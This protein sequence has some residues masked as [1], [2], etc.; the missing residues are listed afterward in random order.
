M[1]ETQSCEMNIVDFN[2]RVID[3]HNAHYTNNPYGL[4]DHSKNASPNGNHIYHLYSN[5]EITF[6]KGAWAYMQRS[7]FNKDYQLSG[8]RKIPFKFVKE[9]ADG[10]TYAILTYEECK[11]FREEMQSYIK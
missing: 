9:A 2:Q 11:L 8:A 4:I 6:Q 7:E 3:A 5:G 10:T 1:P